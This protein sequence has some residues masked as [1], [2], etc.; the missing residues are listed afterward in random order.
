VVILNAAIR[1]AT[2]TAL[3]QKEHPIGPLVAGTPVRASGIT[4]THD[5]W[6]SMSTFYEALRIEL[7]RLLTA[8]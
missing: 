2:T 1:R 4:N 3:Q 8:H 7:R 6:T 5:P